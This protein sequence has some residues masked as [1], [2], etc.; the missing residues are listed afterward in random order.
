[1]REIKFR[2]LKIDGSGWG[3]GTG[4][5]NGYIIDFIVHD[6]RREFIYFEVKPE[7]VGQYTGMKD[8]NVNE[9]YER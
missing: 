8:K 4:Y 9:I 5:N 1:M 7:S 6:N 3:Y 2:G